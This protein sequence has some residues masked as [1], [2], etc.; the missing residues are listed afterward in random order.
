MREEFTEILEAVRQA[1]SASVVI[2]SLQR[3]VGSLSDLQRSELPWGLQAE[4]DTPSQ[5]ALWALHM[6]KAPDAAPSP[7]YGRMSKLL[8]EAAMRLAWL[9]TPDD[10]YSN[11][12]RGDEVAG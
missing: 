5:V 4:L 12:E 3:F 9:G 10:W 8:S 11:N 7:T 6:R 1:H 2:E